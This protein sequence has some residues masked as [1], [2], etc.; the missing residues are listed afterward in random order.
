MYD[1]KLAGK[2]RFAQVGLGSRSEMYSMALV[3]GGDHGH[4]LVG[5]CD[6]NPGR[7]N[8][9]AAW[10]GERGVQVKTYAADE[11]DRLMAECKPDCVIVTTQDSAH[12]TYICR[13]ME[14]GCDVITEKPMTISAEKCRR[15]LDTQRATGRQCAVTFNYRYSPPR[16]QVKDLLMSGV[17]GEVLSV[18]FHWMLDTRHGADYYRRWHCNKANSGGLIVHKATHHFDLINWWLSTVPVSVFASGAHNF[19]TPKTADRY[20]LTRRG[21][22]CYGCTEA[23]RCPF[24]LDISQ[25]GLRSLYLDHEQHDGYYRDRCVF[26]PLIDI[27]DTM[28]VIVNYE[29]GVKMSYSLN[30]FMPWEG[31]AVNF[32]GARG[33]L[34]HTAQETVYI[35]GDGTVPGALRPDGA[36]INIYPHFKPGYSVEVW[37]SQGGHGGG[38]EVMLQDI[39]APAPEPD[40]YMRR[41]DQ[42]AGAYSILTG[43][44]ANQSMATG[45]LVTIDSL[46][47]GIGR[48]DY[49]PMPSPQ[50]PIPLP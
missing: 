29:N 10:A 46:V 26:S 27:E 33:R 44:A 49:P 6:T 15:I 9:R 25:A 5:L 38:D 36:S 11:F 3:E 40:K 31:Y 30:S 48:P 18:D 50:D 24:F 34:E 45:Q 32:N 20:G 8:Q 23:G 47:Q 42:R 2:K 19:Y 21:E 12:D 17:I 4:Q 43:V 16:T 14:L 7:L 41:A 28:N 39:F 35:S 22:R 1:D 37:Q 13:A